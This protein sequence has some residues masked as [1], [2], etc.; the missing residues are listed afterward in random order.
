[1]K[2]IIEEQDVFEDGRF[3][4]AH[5]PTITEIDGGL[6]VAFYAGT[7]E[8]HSDV[9]IW[10]SCYLNAQ[11]SAPQMIAE[12]IEHNGSRYACWDPKIVRRNGAEL[13]LFYSIGPDEG[14][15]WGMMR[16]SRDLGKTW[17]R[18]RRLTLDILPY[19]RNAPVT[20]GND[21]LVLS[22]DQSTGRSVNLR[23]K[24]EGTFAPLR[25][26]IV[27]YPNDRMQLLVRNDTGMLQERWS[28]DGGKSWSNVENNSIRHANSFMDAIRLHDDR[29]LLVYNPS[30][31]GE[32]WPLALTVTVDGK[33]WADVHVLEVDQ[34]RFSGPVLLQTADNMVHVIYAIQ[35]RR[36]RHIIV[37]PEAL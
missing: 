23:L 25:L 31:T 7:T 26:P 11:W 9:C 16:R 3:P 22:T 28:D 17:T 21:V 10:F 37:N 18:P 15:N 8:G 27:T 34:G 1:M 4:Y 35:P 5:M 29:V 2:H 33:M 24:A 20:V 12:G 14:G 30:A 32:R 36:L 6:A 13:I 19:T